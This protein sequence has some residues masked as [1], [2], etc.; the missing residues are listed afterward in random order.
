[1]SEVSKIGKEIAPVLKWVGGKR[2]LLDE[3]VSRIPD[4]TEYIEP[5]AGGAAVLLHLCPSRALLND[6]NSE[7]MNVYSTIKQAP[8]LL[9]KKLEAHANNHSEEYFYKVRALDRDKAYKD[10]SPAHRAARILYLNKTC[11][12]GMFRVNSSGEF[13]VPCGR[14]KNP[15]IVNSASINALSRYL[16]ENDVRLLNTDYKKALTGLTS[17]CFVY[18]DPPY[19]PISPSSS[20]TG[21]TENGFTLKAQ[22]ELKSVCDDLTDRGIKFM[23]SNSNSDYIRELYKD[24]NI[25]TVKARRALNSQAAKRGEIDELL[26]TNY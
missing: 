13:N 23:E 8:A 18:L 3:I 4:F 16:N 22:N 9:I 11:F 26:I 12:N 24:Y 20:F 7:L 19:A 5:F 10:L 21:Y 2:Q 17:G 14:Y 25:S 15:Q 6:S 1:M